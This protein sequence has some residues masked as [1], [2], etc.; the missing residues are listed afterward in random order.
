MRELLTETDIMTGAKFSEDD[1]YRYALWRFWNYGVAKEGTARAVMFIMA[2]S[3]TAGGQRDDPTIR[4]CAKYGQ[5]LGFDGMYVGNLYPRIDTYSRFNG[6]TEEQL[7]GDKADDWLGM[8]RDSSVLHIA[9][10]GFMGGRYPERAK[11]VRAM[12]PELYYLELS[13]DGIPKHPLYLKANLE[14]VLW[15]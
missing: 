15:E 1:V 9:A 12:F 3:S 6:L 10:W 8:M 7:L 4:K 5:R 14:P 11:A 2:N 13:K